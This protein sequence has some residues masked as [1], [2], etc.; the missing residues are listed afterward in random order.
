MSRKNKGYEN[1]DEKNYLKNRVTD[2]DPFMNNVDN[3]IK[4]NI[5]HQFIAFYIYSGNDQEAF[6]DEDSLDAQI[7]TA[8]E[9]LSNCN[10]IPVSI[11]R[12]KNILKVNY[13]REVTSEK[14][15]KLENTTY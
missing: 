6:W 14:P 2:F 4:E 8:I 15:L 10:F 12:I 3:Y 11:E 7:N 5:I 1:E 13:G 9:I